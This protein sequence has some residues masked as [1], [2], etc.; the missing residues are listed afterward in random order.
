MDGQY[1]IKY[2]INLF[3]EHVW[4]DETWGMNKMNVIYPATTPFIPKPLVLTDGRYC[5]SLM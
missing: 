4:E 1:G 5:G 2:S 3:L